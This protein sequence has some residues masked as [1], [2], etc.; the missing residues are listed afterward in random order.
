MEKIQALNAGGTSFLIIEHNMDVVMT[1]CRPIVVMA[2][3]RVIYSG[4]ADGARRDPGVLDAY[5][6]DVGP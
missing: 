5:L 6:G 1:L 3:G 2:A 4:D